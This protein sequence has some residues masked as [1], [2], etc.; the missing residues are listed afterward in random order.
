MCHFL[1]PLLASVFQE[2]R[3]VAEIADQVERCPERNDILEEEQAQET[4]VPYPVNLNYRAWGCRD[5][6]AGCKEHD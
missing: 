3:L 2:D 6:G 4:H 1:L 5:H